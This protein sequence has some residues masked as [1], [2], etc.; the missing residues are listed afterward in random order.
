MLHLSAAYLVI[1]FA[2]LAVMMLVAAHYWRNARQARAEVAEL[3]AAQ[4]LFQSLLDSSP[5]PVLVVSHEHRILKVSEPYAMLCGVSTDDLV[6]KPL[7]HS[8]TTSRF[9]DLGGLLEL[10]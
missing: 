3:Q 9:R 4:A 7:V 10:T 1:P 5:N 6:G 8:H 2:L